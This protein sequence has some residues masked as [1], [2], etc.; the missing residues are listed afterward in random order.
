MEVFGRESRSFF[1]TET[2]VYD[3]GIPHPG[4]GYHHLLP[5]AFHSLVRARHSSPP[6]KQPASAGGNSGSFWEAMFWGA[7]F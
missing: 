5:V 1:P 6:R 2:V 7:V 3:P 4:L